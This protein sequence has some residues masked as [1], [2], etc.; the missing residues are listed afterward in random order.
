MDDSI[1]LAYYHITAGS[2]FALALKYAGTAS[3]EAVKI[4]GDLYEYFRR[5]LVPSSSYLFILLFL[6]VLWLTDQC[7]TFF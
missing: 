3:E 7:V 2:A 1:E 4:I 5:A 6:L